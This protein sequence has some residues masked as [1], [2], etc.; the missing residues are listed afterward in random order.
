MS[1]YEW[2]CPGCQRTFHR[3][4]DNIR[5]WSGAFQIP[6]DTGTKTVNTLCD[7]CHREF[8]RE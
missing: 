6:D 3:M 7:D 4:F 8:I 1:D 5:D 2:T